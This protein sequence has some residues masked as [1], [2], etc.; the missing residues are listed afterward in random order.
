[1]PSRIGKILIEHSTNPV[2]E[3]GG[4]FIFFQLKRTDFY[5]FLWRSLRLQ[6]YG[7]K[8]CSILLNFTAF[9]RCNGLA[10]IRHGKD[11][12]IVLFIIRY[13]FHIAKSRKLL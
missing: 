7:D 12:R 2:W 1:M 6:G 5:N 4:F 8:M 10:V 9:N 11:I 3:K 13:I